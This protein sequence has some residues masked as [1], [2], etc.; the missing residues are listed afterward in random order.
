MDLKEIEWGGVNWMNLGRDRD[1][2]WAVVNTNEPWGS[3]YGRE[4]LD[5]L[6]DY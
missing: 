1:Q 6:S 4:F 3:I 2:W 5:Y